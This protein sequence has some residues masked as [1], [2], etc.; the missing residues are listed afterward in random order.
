MIPPRLNRGP[1]APKI[2][3][4]GYLVKK[5]RRIIYRPWS[6]RYFILDENN[7]LFYY[8]GTVLKGRI[9]MKD[10]QIR[11]LLPHEANGR[12]FA[13]EIFDIND[14]FPRC[15]RLTLAATNIQEAQSWYETISMRLDVNRDSYHSINP[16]H[17]VRTLQ[18]ILNVTYHLLNLFLNR[19]ETLVFIAS[20]WWYRFF[21]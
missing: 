19:R 2:V 4:E 3:K 15:G 10:V 6:V 18:T 9:Q 17:H 5:G 16:E 1:A 7:F 20:M 14:S 13:F 8:K 21:T 12:H 11:Y